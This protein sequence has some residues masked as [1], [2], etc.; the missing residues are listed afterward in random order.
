MNIINKYPFSEHNSYDFNSPF[1]RVD[2]VRYCL[3]EGVCLIDRYVCRTRFLEHAKSNLSSLFLGVGS[4]SLL[5]SFGNFIGDIF[6]GEKDMD[7][8]VNPKN[9][10]SFYDLMCGD[11]IREYVLTQVDPELKFFALEK[12]PF[13][14][15]TIPPLL[16]VVLSSERSRFFD[17]CDPRAAIIHS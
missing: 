3:S 17:N 10:R 1:F 16:I 7:H 4:E 6:S 8:I 5:D 14:D 2:F 13:D 15:P 12:N 9:K 11:F